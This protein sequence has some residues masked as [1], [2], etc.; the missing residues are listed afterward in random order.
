MPRGRSACEEND[1][2]RKEYTVVPTRKCANGGDML[3]PW[4]NSAHGAFSEKH[5]QTPR[6]PAAKEGGGQARL[7]R[8]VRTDGKRERLKQG[9]NPGLQGSVDAGSSLVVAISSTGSG[10]SQ[11]V[12][13]EQ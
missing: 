6:S 1:Y 8:P 9:R 13:T 3:T 7:A 12:S 2:P 4:Q 5:L 10:G 11:I